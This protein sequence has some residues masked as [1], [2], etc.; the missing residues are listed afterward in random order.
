MALVIAIVVFI[1]VTSVIVLFGYYRYVLAGRVYKNLEGRVD[2]ATSTGSSA[3]RESSSISRAAEFVGRKL[4][5]SA[6]TASAL[7]L[8]LMAAGY[9]A[10][11]AVAVFYG[12]KL[13]VMVG[14]TLLM[15]LLEL[16][17]PAAPLVRIVGIALGVLA[18]YKLPDYFLARRIKRRRKKLRKALP[19]ALDLVV[20]CAEAGLTIDRCFRNVSQQLGLVHPELCDEFTL[21]TAE[22][23][24]GL[25]RKEALENLAT[26]T[27]EAEIRKFVA[28]L[29]Q[30]DRFGTSMADALR[31]HAEYLR[32]RRRQEA[33]ESAS[34][35]GVKLIFPIFFFIMPCMIVVTVGPAAIMVGKQLGGIF[36]GPH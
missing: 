21:F 27:Q 6:E 26:R 11:N 9:R 15:L 1:G 7:Q 29:I 20:V 24:A 35:L 18:G 28:V 36:G 30:A 33:E 4:P 22:I 13:M 23:S 31:T 3:G 8:K 2:F 10:Q 34:K 32:I 17:S 25:R 12:I 19:D 5:P 14:L 16:N